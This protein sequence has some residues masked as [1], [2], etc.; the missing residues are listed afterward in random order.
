LLVTGETRIPTGCAI[1]LT[2]LW[3]RGEPRAGEP[4]QVTIGLEAIGATYGAMRAAFDRGLTRLVER[5]GSLV[6]RL[7]DSRGYPEWLAGLGR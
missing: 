7:E 6:L 2:H 5:A 4:E 3:W 1:E